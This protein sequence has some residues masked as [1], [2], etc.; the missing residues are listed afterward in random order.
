MPLLDVTGDREWTTGT[1][2]CC[3]DVAGMIDSILCPCC[4]MGRHCAA[5]G[6]QT[7]TMDFMWCVIPFL[8]GCGNACYICQIRSRIRTR[9][10]I[11]GSPVMDAFWSFCCPSCAFCQNGREL[12]NR[13]F[14][15]GGTCP[16][17]SNP[18][19]GMG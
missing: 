9:F 5:L 15:P 14:W 8:F 17:N 16:I 6:G 4:Q 18:P 1:F 7:N 13:G 11:D 2:G 19:G 12:T 10:E 3:E